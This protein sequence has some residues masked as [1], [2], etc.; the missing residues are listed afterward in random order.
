[1][2]DDFGFSIDWLALAIQ[3]TGWFGCSSG[4]GSLSCICVLQSGLRVTVDR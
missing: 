2:K 4:L 1:M 3:T